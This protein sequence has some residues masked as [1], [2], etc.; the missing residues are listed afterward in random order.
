[1]P[2]R[3]LLE[4]ATFDLGSALIAAEAGADRIELCRAPA[5]GGLTPPHPWTDAAVAT[6]VPIAVMI[7]AHS[8]GWTFT[9]EEH[10]T[11]RADARAASDAGAAAIVWGA[12]TPEGTIDSAALRALV[13][14]VAPTP[15]VFHRAFDATPDLDE[16]LDTLIDCGVAR[17]LTSGGTDTA[18]AG[19]AR[20]A[21]LVRR[22]ANDIGILPG[23]G[24]RSSNA[25]EIV[26]LTGASEVHSRAA[27][28]GADIANAGEVRQIRAALDSM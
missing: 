3:V 2:D 10:A 20:L 14:W 15:V 4:I 19:A 1:M 26:R 11:M 5:E 23:G 28:P 18:M 6:G 27:E 22:A 24:I 21:E 13:Q 17:V 25:A 8:K 7:R 9:A 16:A 12:L